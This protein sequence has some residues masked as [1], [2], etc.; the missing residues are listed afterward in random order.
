MEAGGFF[1]GLCLAP[2]LHFRGD[3]LSRDYAVESAVGLWVETATSV[4]RQACWWSDDVHAVD[5]Q[6]RRAV[7]TEVRGVLD[8]ADVDALDVRGVAIVCQC[9]ACVGLGPLGM[10]AALGRQQLNA[11]G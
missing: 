10:R 7:E 3:G 8:I 6:C 2:P 5:A 11:H 9:R 1:A 4:D